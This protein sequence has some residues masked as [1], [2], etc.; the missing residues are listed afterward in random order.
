MYKR[1]IAFVFFCVWGMMP[2]LAQ[3]NVT[4]IKQG[5]ALHEE[6]RFEEAIR[7]YDEVIS[8]DPKNVLAQYEKS[9]SLLMSQQYD[10]A[11]KMSKDIIAAF[12]NDENIPNVYINW[13]TAL[14][15]QRKPKDAIKV[16]EKALK[17]YPGHY[18][19]LFNKAI[20]NDSRG[21]RED[22]IAD[23]Q[24]ALRSNPLHPSSH[25]ALGLLTTGSNK[26]AGMLSNLAYLAIQPQ[27]T[28]RANYNRGQVEKLI[29]RSAEKKD[30][31]NITV[32]LS[33]PSGK[34]KEN[35]F[36]SLEL[37][38]GLTAAT[39]HM[40]EHE[41][42]TDTER[43]QR[44]LGT[45]FS[46]LSLGQKEGKG[47]YWEFYAPFFASLEKEGFRETFVHVMYTTSGNVLNELWLHDNRPKVDSFKKWLAAYKWTKN[48]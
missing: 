28:D 45:L 44:N 34:K 40:K 31:K 21:E 7:L 8:A 15:Y 42:E 33:L 5:I 41:N 22:A 16:Y 26:I 47:F 43:M 36:S 46:G 17:A 24:Q 23:L 32:S 1:G 11:I 39:N 30:D 27:A 4:K 48:G 38:I 2:L 10:A 29:G 9:Y 35:D 14:D 18:L 19:L 13:G 25:H 6:G 3:D 37:M 20:S 12:P